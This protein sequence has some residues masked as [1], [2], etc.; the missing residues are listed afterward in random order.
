MIQLV[1]LCLIVTV[2]GAFGKEIRIP[3][4]SSIDDLLTEAK[5]NIP[6]DIPEDDAEIIPTN[7]NFVIKVKHTLSAHAQLDSL[8]TNRMCY[9]CK[10]RYTRYVTD[11]STM[12]PILQFSLSIWNV[13]RYQF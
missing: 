8:F 2:V 3:E 13:L 12:T 10:W 6:Y 1:S 7:G 11:I 9:C 5:A 4:N